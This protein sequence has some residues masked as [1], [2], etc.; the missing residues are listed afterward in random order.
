MRL[1]HITDPH[2]TS[3]DAWRPGPS[4]GKRWLSWLSWQ[5]RRRKV[6]RPARLTALTAH[7]EAAR[8]DVWAITGDLCQL[9]LEQEAREAAAWLN[10]LASADRVL[11]VPGNHDVF[12][13]DSS[14]SILRHWSDWLH[15]DPAAPEWPVVRAF[16]EATLIGLNSAVVTPILKAGGRLGEAMRRRLDHALEKSRGSC[17]VVMI[18]HPP[19]PGSC[20]PRKALADDRELTELLKRRGAALVLHGHLHHNREYRLASSDGGETAVFCTASASAAGSQGPAAARIFD[21]EPAPGGYRVSMR[22]EALDASNRGH[23]IERSEW[24]SRG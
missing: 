14:D 18:H 13:T 10:R 5:N 17:R 3:L 6:H 4:A 22:L 21:I 20:K 8:P 19:L 24:I 2:L 16:G 1:I 15:V 23:T 12:A 7:L 11:L 9:G